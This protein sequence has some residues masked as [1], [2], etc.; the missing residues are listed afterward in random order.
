MLLRK[1][2]K[3]TAK[4]KKMNLRSDENPSQDRRIRAQPS[5]LIIPT[6]SVSSAVKV[7]FFLESGFVRG[8]CMACGSLEAGLPAKLAVQ[9]AAAF[10]G[11]QKIGA[12][13]RLGICM[14]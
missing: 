8:G 13:C 6:N 9:T 11:E 2:A 14:F 10:A 4:I 1:S 7:F 3:T 5:H 12:K